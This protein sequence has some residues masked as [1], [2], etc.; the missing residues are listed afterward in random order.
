MSSVPNDVKL[1]I[2]AINKQKIYYV[3]A[4]YTKI[5]SVAN[6]KNKFYI[7]SNFHYV[8]QQKFYHDKQEIIEKYIWILYSL[9]KNIDHPELIQEWKQNIDAVDYEQK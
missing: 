9:I 4:C 6:T 3:M 8:Y 5:S 1:R 7:L 2:H